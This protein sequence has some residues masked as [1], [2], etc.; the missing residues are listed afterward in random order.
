MGR[1]TQATLRTLPESVLGEAI[2][3]A[4]IG[5]LRAAGAFGVNA[6]WLAQRWEGKLKGFTLA[7]SVLGHAYIHLGQADIVRG[8]LGLPGI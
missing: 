1:Q 2:D 7:Q 5:R 3:S 4:V 8:L 6:D